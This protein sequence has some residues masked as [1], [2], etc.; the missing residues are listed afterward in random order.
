M[1][2][3]IG[4][5]ALLICALFWVGCGDKGKPSVSAKEPASSI[6]V[7]PHRTIETMQS[8][9]AVLFPEDGTVP[10]W[11]KGGETAFFDQNSLFRHINGA[12]GTFFAYGFQLCGAAEYIPDSG[13]GEKTLSPEDEFIQIDIYDMGRAI[14]A[15]GM[16]TSES[17]SESEAVDIGAQGYIEPP[18]LNFWKGP[19][20]VKI[21]A[22]RPVEDLT[23]ANIELANYIAQKIPGKAEKPPMLSLLP[24]RWLLPGT[25]RFI[26]NHILGYSF[27]KNGV[28]ATYQV[29]GEEKSLLIMECESIDD[30]K[31]RLDQFLRYEEETGEGAVKVSRLGEEGFAANDRYYE[32]LIAVR[33]GPYLI[34]TLTVTDEAAARELIKEAMDNINRQE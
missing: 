15:F 30:A 19:Y 33:R 5:I 29:G 1:T 32:R 21:A 23:K 9:M 16:Y 4:Q 27:L 24:T 3:R 2:R 13:A 34:V 7:E 22:S 31:D 17:Y 26:L 28:M 25:E 14:H 10:G 6:A 11:R 20:Y 18:A 12:A 8:Q